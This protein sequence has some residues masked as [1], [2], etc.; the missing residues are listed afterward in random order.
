M[1]ARLNG[2]RGEVASLPLPLPKKVGL[3]F[4]SDATS[5]S[6]VK[7]DE[8]TRSGSELRPSALGVSHRVFRGLESHFGHIRYQWFYLH[9]LNGH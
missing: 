7:S 6:L 4:R 8:Q 2:S 1:I 9:V 3:V 5:G